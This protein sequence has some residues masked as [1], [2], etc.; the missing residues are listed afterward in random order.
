MF[1]WRGLFVSVK[2]VP[3]SCVSPEHVCRQLFHHLAFS[4]TLPSTAT[5]DCSHVMISPNH[6]VNSST[7]SPLPG[8]CVPATAGMHAE[9]LVCTA[10]ITGSRLFAPSSRVSLR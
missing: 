1:I 4:L 2:P 6:L 8:A 5:T 10:Y 7:P 9:L 3:A